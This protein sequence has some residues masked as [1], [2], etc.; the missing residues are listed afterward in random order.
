M[1]LNDYT[2]KRDFEKTPEPKPGEASEQGGLRF[3]VHKHAARAMHYDLR[4]ELEGTLK[5]WAVPKGPSLD[6]SSKRLAVQVEDHPLEYRDFE[7]V[8]PEDNY[9][10]GSVIIW[11]RGVYHHPTT[12]DELQSRTRLLEGF[13]RGDMKFVLE[14]EKLHGEFA[15]VKTAKDGT[16]WLLIKK[17]DGSADTEDVLRQNRSVVSH[18]TL[19]EVLEAEAGKPFAVKKS[20]QI[21]IH[22]AVESGDLEGV[23]VQPMPRD[24]QPMLASSIREPFN[25]PEWVFEVKWDGYRAIA[26]IRQ[27]SAS[28]TSRNGIS[29]VKKFSPLVASL[30]KFGFDAVLDGEVVVVDDQ[31]RPDFQAVQQYDALQ[32]GHLIYYVFDLLHFQGYDLTHVPLIRRKALL[33]KVLPALPGIRLSDHIE[34]DGVAYFALAREKGLEGIVAKYGRSVYEAG[35]R[36]R[37]WLKIKTRLTQEA[38]IAG[39]TEPGGGRQHIGALVLGAYVSDE[40]AFIGHVGSGFSAKDL[41]SIGKMLASRVVRECPFRIEPATNAPVTWVKP[42]LVCEVAFSGWT[43]EHALRHPVFLRLRDDKNAHDALMEK[44]SSDADE[45]GSGKE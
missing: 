34:K 16:S 4:L 1:A 39:F 27:G 37:Q 15:L 19:E 22:E 31:G 38:V 40:L 5:S 32:G 12:R 25:D 10:A 41:E 14:G 24:M 11:D 13:R 9:G 36:T 45:H 29:F 42:E 3:V 2:T 23:P 33:K 26:E 21:R 43:G 18:K 7:G 20:N 6:P 35:T 30:R 17:K 28:L 44:D 8:I